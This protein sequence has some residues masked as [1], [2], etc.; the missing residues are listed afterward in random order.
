MGE[1]LDPTDLQHLGKLR[2][3]IV[4]KTFDNFPLL[5]L[6][7]V[8]FRYIQ[9]TEPKQEAVR[10]QESQ[11]PLQLLQQVCENTKKVCVDV[12]FLIL[13]AVAAVLSL[14]YHKIP[15][16]PSCVSAG[17]FTW[18]LSSTIRI[19]YWWQRRTRS[20][21][22]RWTTHTAAP[23]CRTSSGSLRYSMKADTNKAQR[24]RYSRNLTLQKV[25]PWKQL[26]IYVSMTGNQV[27]KFPSVTSSSFISE[28]IHIQL[29]TSVK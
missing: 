28:C 29:L 2:E 1:W 12:E 4:H 9:A 20:P 22:W 7:F 14:T 15:P 26:F 24:K 6:S 25:S 21:S 13:S 5:F 16:S 19:V 18:P 17:G 8:V 10:L 27:R 11:T 23:S 3:R